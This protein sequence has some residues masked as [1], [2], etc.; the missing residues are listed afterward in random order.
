[1]VPVA[2]EIAP[3]EARREQFS[4]SKLT[5]SNKEWCYFSHNPSGQDHFFAQRRY[6]SFM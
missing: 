6:Q 4:H 5:M 2:T 3:I 1:M